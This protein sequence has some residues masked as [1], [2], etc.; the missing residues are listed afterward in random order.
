MALVPC[1]STYEQSWEYIQTLQQQ[2]LNSRR[3]LETTTTALDRHKLLVTA[4]GSG[5]VERV[6]RLVRVGLKQGAG[7][8]RLL[9]MYDR[10]CQERED[11]MRTLLL[12]KLGG[13]RIG[14]IA[15]KA[16]SLPAVN[17]VR[18]RCLVPMIEASPS[19]PQLTTIEK[20]VGSS[21]A[22]ITEVVRK[23]RIVHQSVMFDEIKCELRARW[24]PRTNFILGICR[25]HGERVSLEFKS[26]NEAS[27]F[28]EA[29]EENQVHLATEV[30]VGA[31][32][33]LTG[34]SRLYSTCK[35]EKDV[36]H[37][38]LIVTTVKACAETQIRTICLASDGDLMRGK[39]LIRLTFKHTLP[40]DSPL[41]SILSRLH[42]MNLEVGDDDLTADKDYKHVF[43]RFRNLCLR[44]KRIHTD[45]GLDTVRISNLLNPRDKH[46][47][48]LAYNLLKEI[49]SLTETPA[50]TNPRPGFIATRDALRTMG[51]LFQHLLM[52][53]ICVD[54]TLS[55]QLKHL[56]SA[57]HMILA[58]FV[59]EMS[60]FASA[61]AQF[62]DPEGHF[63]LVL[64]GTDRLEEIF[65]NVRTM[66]GNNVNVDVLQLEERITRAT[67]VS[68]ILALY[69][70][71]D[72]PSRRS[73]HPC[74][75]P[76]WCYP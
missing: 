50:S 54:L 9:R 11:Y 29:R 23:K 38:K 35:A 16:L 52:P 17:T 14:N 64:L 44:S 19:I 32:G 25:E 69:P 34:E 36:D 39:A 55:D 53:Y 70:D 66:V 12:W 5:K 13:Q 45:N 22:A 27:L 42:F 65:G 57:A 59:E 75:D 48:N 24:N 62:D 51:D 43:K 61:K 67:E 2:G 56:S 7:I 74:P 4:V 49:W 63:W 37:A 20:N 71:W 21:F 47:V 30:T 60:S 18:S 1:S 72:T 46:N 31:I 40:E 26:E 33:L 58:L 3:R 8:K 73:K 15:H 6:D 41:H 76:G 28:K 68:T 10:S